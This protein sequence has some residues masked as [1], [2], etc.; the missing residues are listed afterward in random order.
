MC[1]SDEFLSYLNDPQYLSNLL[2]EKSNTIIDDSIFFHIANHFLCKDIS[3]EG[4]SVQRNLY[5]RPRSSS[6]NKCEIDLFILN[7]KECI[8]SNSEQLTKLFLQYLHNIN[9]LLPNYFRDIAYLC[10]LIILPHSN[11]NVLSCILCAFIEM[12]TLNNLRYDLIINGLYK[13]EDEQE[14][15]PWIDHL[16]KLIVEKDNQ[17]LRKF[18]LEKIYTKQLLHAIDTHDQEKIFNIQPIKINSEELSLKTIE[19]IDLSEVS[20][21]DDLHSRLLFYVSNNLHNNSIDELCLFNLFSSSNN[22]PNDLHILFS[23][24]LISI[25]DKNNY[26]ILSLRLFRRLILLINNYY[27]NQQDLFDDNRYRL[28]IVYLVSKLIC[29]LH[30]RRSKSEHEW[31]CLY[32]DIPKEHP[33]PTFDLFSDLICLLATLCYNHIQCQNQVRQTSGTIES[34]L[35]MTQIDLNQP[36]AQASV[37]WLIKCLTENNEENRNYIKQIK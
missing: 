23:C 31:Y 16:T 12:N 14:D 21:L 19:K 32:I 35:S 25:I 2:K 3:I 28:I 5:G 1:S 17:W 10:A 8:N 11:K 18:Y 6:L 30:Q 22:Y 27:I 37:T 7:I 4:L 34:I 33:L 9:R 20:T 13:N 26:S 36:K 29:E 15:N 24:L